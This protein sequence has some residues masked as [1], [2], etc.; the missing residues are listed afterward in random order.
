MSQFELALRKYIAA[1]DRKNDISPTEFQARFD[2]LFHED[3]TFLPKYGREMGEEGF[4]AIKPE[5][6]LTREELF[7]L[8]SNKLNSG[9]KVTLIHF[10]KIGLG[11]RDI[12]LCVADGEE[13]TTARVVMTISAKKAFVSQEI[14]DSPE[15][16]LFFPTQLL[17]ASCASYAYKLKNVNH[18]Q[19]LRSAV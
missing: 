1:F 8:E 7:E 6:P 13:E 2:N 18:F 4:Q 3:F 10:R 9:I 16:N 14:D 11:C 17:H 12:K 19:A 15:S 5:A